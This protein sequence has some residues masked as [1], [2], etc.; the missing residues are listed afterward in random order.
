MSIKDTLTTKG[1]F[2]TGNGFNIEF[3]NDEYNFHYPKF[4]EYPP[5][6]KFFISNIINISSSFTGMKEIDGE[7]NIINISY[8]YLIKKYKEMSI[9]NNAIRID[10]ESF[11]FFVELFLLA[12]NKQSNHLAIYLW[13]KTLFN[14]NAMITEDYRVFFIKEIL[15]MDWFWGIKQWIIQSENG[16]NNIEEW[17]IDTLIYL[18]KIRT[19]AI[20]VMSKKYM[21]NID[22]KITR[23]SVLR[24]G[25][26]RKL[27][28]I[29]FTNSILIT[30]NYDQY[31]LI[32]H[33]EEKWEW[34]MKYI[35]SYDFPKNEINLINPTSEWGGF[36]KEYRHLHGSFL[37][38]TFLFDRTIY[39]N[40]GISLMILLGNPLT[41]KLTSVP[42]RVVHDLVTGKIENG[43]DDIFEGHKKIS[44]YGLDILKEFLIMENIA[45]SKGADII[46]FYNKKEYLKENKN[47]LKIFKNILK[48]KNK[49]IKFRSK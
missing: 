34:M 16:K 9:T 10:I 5:E 44:I 38:R 19:F 15:N 37:F 48:S 36:L 28:K 42:N 43:Y 30:T 14:I 32:I 31:G 8:N 27:R 47:E 21:K 13:E 23:Q 35:S 45:T 39:Y 24:K 4:K 3:V 33:N 49:K 22:K 7:N 17:K 18:H 40:I 25:K 20:E 12:G 1:L 46:F 6:F 11:S 41:T 26:E 29:K 2:V